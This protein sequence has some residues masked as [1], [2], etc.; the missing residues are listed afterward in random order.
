MTK[1]KALSLEL[2]TTWVTTEMLLFFLRLI[3][4]YYILIKI[5]SMYAGFKT[6][7]KVKC[8]RDPKGQEKKQENPVAQIM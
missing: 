3:K 4:G 5:I 8:M 7:V 2:G 6:Y 1:K